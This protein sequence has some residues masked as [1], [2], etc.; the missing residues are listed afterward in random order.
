MRLT[1]R[2]MS[3]CKPFELLKRD[4]SP[5]NASPSR[6]G[7]SSCCFSLARLGFSLGCLEKRLIRFYQTYNNYRSHSGIL[8]IPPA[9]FWALNQ[10]DQIEVIPLDKRRLR[11]RLKVKVTYQDIMTLPNIDQYEYR[12]VSQKETLALFLKSLK[13]RKSNVLVGLLNTHIRH[14]YNGHRQSTLA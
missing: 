11:F 8:G 9:K 10:M 3:V 4:L 12:V 13:D 7:R 1:L 14:R 5:E 6:Q 2:I